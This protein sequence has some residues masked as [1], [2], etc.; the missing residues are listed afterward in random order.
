MPADLV[1]E[2]FEP[3]RRLHRR[4]RAPGEGAGLG[5]SIVASIV[6]AHGATVTASANTDGGLT[7]RVSFAQRG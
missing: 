1:D 2:L 5:L 4:S 7:L 6:Q 3:F